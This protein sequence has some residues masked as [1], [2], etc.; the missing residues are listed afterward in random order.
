MSCQFWMSN[1]KGCFFFPLFYWFQGSPSYNIINLGEGGTNP[2][3]VFLPF[4]KKKRGGGTKTFT[5]CTFF[6]QSCS[7]K[8]KI[9]LGGRFLIRVKRGLNE[10]PIQVSLLSERSSPSVCCRSS[11]NLPVFLSLGLRLNCVNTFPS[12]VHTAWILFCFPRRR[13]ALQYDCS[14]YTHLRALKP[15]LPSF[16]P[17]F[18]PSLLPSLLLSFFVSFFF[19][20]F[21]PLYIFPTTF[22][23]AWN[24]H[25]AVAFS[26]FCI[27]CT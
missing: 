18:F 17:S 7:H 11:N 3:F 26:F 27:S 22:I 2:F 24:T 20:L 1:F 19:S 8:M 13:P 23:Y 6:W 4:I 16:L 9:C 12:L 21:G 5:R 14:I 10:F 15:L 25:I